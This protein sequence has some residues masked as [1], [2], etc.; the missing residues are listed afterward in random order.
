M[1]KL[2]HD[3][4]KKHIETLLESEALEISCDEHHIYIPYMMNDAVECYLCFPEGQLK[5]QLLS[6][7]KGE[8]SA[9]FLFSVPDA[10]G[11]SGKHALIF[12]QH[13]IA[14]HSSNI[15][16]LWFTEVQKYLNC[17]QYHRIGHFWTPGM[18]HWRRLVY[19]I[20]TITDKYTYMGAQYCT[21][22]EKSLLPLMEFAPFRMYSPISESLDAWYQ[23]SPEGYTCMEQLAAQAG[24]LVFV[25]LLRFLRFFDAPFFVR[26]WKNRFL[27]RVLNQPGRIDLYQLIYH[28]IEEA[29]LDYPERNYG[30]DRNNEIR[31]L[32][33][34]FTSQLLSEGY[35]GSYPLFQKDRKQILA[36]EE[37]PFTI[38]ES[39]DFTFHIQFMESETDDGDTRINAGFF[40]KKRNHACIKKGL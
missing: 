14:D 31:F 15:C 7:F 29:S 25:R 17:Y 39:S 19:I 21:E 40:R 20:G 23:D 2:S 22:K 27:Y 10:S 9:E 12:R 3:E 38:L 30:A 35:S 36:M 28:L 34:Q 26:R 11:N 1:Q 33:Q 18:E 6:D 4:L 5:G 37:H 16:T 32:R 13:N 8:T 24:D